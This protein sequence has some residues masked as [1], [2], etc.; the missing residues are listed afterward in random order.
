MDI[1]LLTKSRIV[2]VV[3]LIFIT[4]FA[5]FSELDISA[6]QHVGAGLK[7]ALVTFGVAKTLNAAI[8][9]GQSAQFSIQPMGIGL[10]LTIGEVLDPINDLVEQFSTFMIAAAVA[11]G[12]QKT[13]I[14]IGGSFGVKVVLTICSCLLG[15]LYCLKQNSPSWLSKALALI[16]L[17]RFAVP[18][19]T[20][21]SDYLFEKFMSPDY[22]TSQ[23]SMSSATTQINSVTPNKLSSQSKP[24]TP[25]STGIF[26]WMKPY[27][28]SIP[29]VSDVKWE[30]E[31]LR[32][33]IDFITEKVTMDIVN[34]IVYFTLQT[35]IFPLLMIWGLYR[36]SVGILSA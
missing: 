12:I 24:Y 23:L 3:V 21:G 11:F 15:V 4:I 33:K 8:S 29:S 30:V 7:R 2:I 32:Q 14:A 5:W 16:I 10:A 20:V 9:V 25:D 17:L 35:L 26:D 6:N 22:Q 28:P 1:S 27:L 13:L 18:L 36:I 31:Q 19:A 34:M